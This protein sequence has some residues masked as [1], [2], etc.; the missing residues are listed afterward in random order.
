MADVGFGVSVHVGCWVWMCLTGHLPA[1]KFVPLDMVPVRQQHLFLSPLGQEAA[2]VLTG[3]LAGAP[4]LLGL[5]CVIRDHESIHLQTNM[6]IHTS[7]NKHVP[8]STLL[9]HQ[10]P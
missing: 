3:L 9:F 7:A 4:Q 8:K 6:H 1:K 10:S 2:P 5:A